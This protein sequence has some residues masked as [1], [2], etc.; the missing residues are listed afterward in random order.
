MSVHFTQIKIITFFKITFQK[1]KIHI[2]DV[3]KHDVTVNLEVADVD[4]SNKMELSQS[5]HVYYLI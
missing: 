1:E 5:C 4:G 3:T 2:Q